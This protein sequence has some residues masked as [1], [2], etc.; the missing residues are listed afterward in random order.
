MKN[1]CRTASMA[2]LVIALSHAAVITGHAQSD[3][4]RIRAQRL[5]GYAIEKVADTRT[6]VPAG[7]GNFVEFGLPSIRGGTVA[8]R[9]DGDMGQK[10]VYARVGGTL[11]TVADL[12]TQAP[13]GGG[14]FTFFFRAISER[15][16]I[17]TDGRVS[18]IG[19]TADR[20]A[21]YTNQTGPLTILVDDTFP[22]PG[23]P[24]GKFSGFTA[25]S[26]DGGQVAFTGGGPGFEG[27]YLA[28]GSSISL[29]ADL[30]TPI[31]GGTGNFSGFGS[32]SGAGR[33]SLHAGDVVF[34]GEGG[35]DPSGRDQSGI[36]G[37]IGG[38]LTV[39]AD[40]HTLVPGTTETF[41]RFNDGGN[42]SPDIRDGEVAFENGGIYVARATGLEAVADARTRIPRLPFLKFN[43]FGDV[44]IEEGHVAFGGAYI[45]E[46]GIF[47][48]L[49]ETGL[50]SDIQGRLRAVIARSL[51][52][53]LD[54]KLV[55][56]VFSG[57]EALSEGSFAFKVT[58]HGGAQGIF[59]AKPM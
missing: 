38:T 22:V 52:S 24:G 14:N 4:N 34:I 55:Q 31:P 13:G 1:E 39:I 21:I 16:S 59:V 15:V 5:S 54:R 33:P 11:T 17:S 3:P 43:W 10:G 57:T 35:L 44:A 49:V 58:F 26:Y 37:L 53:P 42:G 20:R 32:S 48:I 29:V 36:Y 30:A 27:L 23:N 6:P 9:A 50:Y 46:F 18:F 19:R 40:R 12:N 8:F 7:T 56:D 51:F 28:D 45:Y 2:T 41:G 25:L 47:P